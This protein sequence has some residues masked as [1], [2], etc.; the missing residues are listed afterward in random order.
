VISVV[1]PARD[2]ER[3]LPGTLDAV[4]GQLD[5][6]EAIVVDNGSSDATAEAARAG[7]ARVISL[8]RPGRAAARNRGAAEATG[9]R[10]AFLDA[11]CRPQPGWAEAIGRCLDAAPLVGGAVAV[12][13]SERP[14]PSE[15]FDALWRFQQERTIREG[16]WAAS[17]NLAL[18]R[19]AFDAVGGFDEAYDSAEDVDLCI[20]AARLGLEIAYCPEAV[21]SHPASR[22]VRE[23]LARGLR[24]GHESTRLHRRLD[25]QVGR[26]YWRRPGGIVRGKAALRA[27]GADPGALDGAERRA[28]ARIARAEYLARFVGSAGAQLRRRP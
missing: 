9:G 6:R 17:A 21:V 8:E 3:E 18:T 7:G 24:Q 19:A 2:A 23:V 27:L 25:G 13:T 10:I 28:M 26:H 1:I 5:V 12:A 14:A 4:V 16:R 22:T 11:D 20:R 15:R